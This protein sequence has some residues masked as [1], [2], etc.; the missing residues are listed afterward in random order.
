MGALWLTPAPH[1]PSKMGP[2]LRA[3]T[4]THSP[5]G[6]HTT[7]RPAVPAPPQH[8][9]TRNQHSPLTHSAHTQDGAPNRRPPV[10][11]AGGLFERL[12][13]W[14]SASHAAHAP[15]SRG[16]DTRFLAHMGK[17]LGLGPSHSCQ[18]PTPCRQDR[19]TG[20]RRLG[21]AFGA[22]W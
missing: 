3:H 17:I 1:R 18:C 21:A 11:Q 20:R 9:T 15:V 10:W 8:P 12:W 4:D 22:R 14:D 2:E 5:Y 7:G 6:S 13:M 19:L 16:T